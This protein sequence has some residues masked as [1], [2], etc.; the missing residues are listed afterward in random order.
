MSVNLAKVK[1][2][3]FD[4]LF[5][6]SGDSNNVRPT[7]QSSSLSSLGK[8][9]PRVLLLDK[10]TTPI[11]SMCY[12]QSQLLANDII[13][14]ELVDNYHQLTSMKHLDCIVY[15]K[16]CLESVNFICQELRNPHFREYRLYLNNCISKNQLESIAEADQ[17]E[18][19]DKVME[20]FE[21]YLIVNDNLYV[22]DTTFQTEL[23]NPVLLES[24]KL[25]SLL[26][27]LKNSDN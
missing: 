23:V 10:F 4:K 19:I 7:T 2:T 27:A 6:T 8:K 12:T 18:A 21:D 17:Y 3:Y 5:S 9:K 13:L 11:I 22:V 20:I 16:P 26:L 24:E 1:D 25:V 14:I 15:I